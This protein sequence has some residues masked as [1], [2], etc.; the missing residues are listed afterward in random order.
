MFIFL[1]KIDDFPSQNICPEKEAETGENS[2]YWR[3]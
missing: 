3:Y 2:G 1:A